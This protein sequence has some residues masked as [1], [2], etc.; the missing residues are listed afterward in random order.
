MA[1]QF[2]YEG[3]TLGSQFKKGVQ[4]FSA[5]QKRAVN[6]AARMAAEEIET[7][8][9]AN[10]RQGGNFGSARWQEGFRAVL[11]FGA[12]VIIRVTHAVP[13]WR[14]F[15]EGRTIRGK[16]LLWIPLSFSDAGRLKVRARDFP[17]KLFRVNRVG[18]A[19]LLLDSTGPQYFGKSQVRIPR[20]WRLRDIVRRVARKMNQFYKE[21][22]R[23]GR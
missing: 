6:A 2:K 11:S 19:P 14:V 13:Y 7:Q 15:E 21:A 1:V 5:K 23:N 9:R 10:I 22:L 3:K 16:P 4:N 20:K 8:G 17:R 18:K 12:N